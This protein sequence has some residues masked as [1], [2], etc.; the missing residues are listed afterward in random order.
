M[1]TP[2]ISRGILLAALAL[3]GFTST[4]SVSTHRLP[5][6]RPMLDGGSS[7]EET[8][9]A[10]E[11]TP[12]KGMRKRTA[13]VRK[14]MAEAQ[15]VVEDQGRIRFAETTRVGSAEGKA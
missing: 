3:A 1:P 5:K 7:R 12:K 2:T 10:S 4:N 15:R 13:A 6:S 11:G 8:S 14:R 9:S